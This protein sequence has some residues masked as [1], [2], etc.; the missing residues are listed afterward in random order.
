[1]DPEPD[2]DVYTVALTDQSKIKARWDTMSNWHQR[3]GHLN[4][5][6]I[7]KLSKD[8]KMGIRITGTKKLPFCQVCI[9]AKQTRASFKRQAPRATR[10]L[11]C[12]HIDISG[13]GET[14][15]DPNKLIFDYNNYNYIMIIIDNMTHFRWG[16]LLQSKDQIYTV[17]ETWIPRMINLLGWGPVI[18]RSDI[19]SVIH[20]HKCQALFQKYS[21][22]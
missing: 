18:V 6:D 14:F 17:L 8:P 12:I 4:A 20:S 3:L 2:T 1:M 10:R 9:Q 22:K 16:F 11:A 15:D 5:A 13:G 7:V 21:M 19:D